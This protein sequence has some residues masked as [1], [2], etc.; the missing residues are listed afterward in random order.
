M[1]QFGDVKVLVVDDQKYITDI[2]KA[3]IETFGV[4]KIDICHNGEDAFSAFCR[5]N[6]DLIIT[7]W[8]LDGM[9]GLELTEKIRTS[10]KSPNRY[11][12][13]LLMTAFSEKHRVFKA[14]DTGITEFLAKPFTANDLY[15][16]IHQVIEKPRDFVLSDKFTGPDR[17][18]KRVV[19][20]NTRFKRE[21]DHN[22]P[23]IQKT[24]FEQSKSRNNEDMDIDLVFSSEES[25]KTKE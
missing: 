8:L 18:R 21:E 10:E 22:D 24:I 5:E 3:I 12:P 15:V 23:E 4:K 9:D 17:R 25:E 13:V 6:H 1:Y 19:D 7:D 11:V 16:R 14:R 2:L 20:E